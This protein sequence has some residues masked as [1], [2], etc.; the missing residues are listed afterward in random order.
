MYIALPAGCTGAVRIKWQARG[1]SAV[2]RPAT[3]L[4]TALAVRSPYS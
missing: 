4:L 3:A 1:A 2:V